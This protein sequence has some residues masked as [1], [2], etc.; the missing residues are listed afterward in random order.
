MA[1]FKRAGRWKVAT[2]TKRAPRQFSLDSAFEERDLEKSAAVLSGGELNRLNLAKLCFRIPTCCCL[3][4]PT[5]HLDISAVRWL[6][7]FLKDYTRSFVVISHDRYF[8]THVTRILEIAEEGGG[9]P[10][11]LSWYTVR[12][13]AAAGTPVKA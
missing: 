3:D 13:G 1:T 11:Q 9:V 10:R 5:N 4:E 8:S 12:T 7:G 6:E 2:P